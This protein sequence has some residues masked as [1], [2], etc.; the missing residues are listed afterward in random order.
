MYSSKK[1]ERL[2][3]LVCHFLMKK[4]HDKLTELM[5]KA[6]CVPWDLAEVP[7]P[8]NEWDAGDAEFLAVQ[9]YMDWATQAASNDGRKAEQL[10]LLKAL[11]V[12]KDGQTT[13]CPFST[14]PDMQQD[15]GTTGNRQP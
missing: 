12:S 15:R 8:V 4:N 5:H 9:A 3:R 1:G 7:E 11:L 13:W 10:I 2:F 6:K 14:V